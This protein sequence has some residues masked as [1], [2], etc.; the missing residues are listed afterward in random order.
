VK[1]RM[2][3]PDNP[4]WSMYELWRY[5]YRFKD[6]C[7]HTRTFTFYLALYDLNPPGFHSFPPDITVA[8]VADVPEIDRDVRIIDICQYVVWD[9]VIT[10]P[11]L[12]Q[13]ETATQRFILRL[14]ANVRCVH[15]MLRHQMIQ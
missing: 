13:S 12:D 11:V 9:T 8:T 7:F 3:L 4:P 6:G 5:E 10:F 15:Q 14:I 1:Q 2:E